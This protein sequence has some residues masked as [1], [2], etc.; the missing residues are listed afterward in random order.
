M[1]VPITQCLLAD[2]GSGLKIAN[3]RPQLTQ[4]LL[5]DIGP[6]SVA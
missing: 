2:T 5:R 4:W 1:L 6:W 3:T